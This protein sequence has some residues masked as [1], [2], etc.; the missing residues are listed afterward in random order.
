MF[1]QFIDKVEGADT[2]MITS[3]I[4]FMA[5]FVVVSLYLFVMDKNY[6]TKMQNLPLEDNQDDYKDVISI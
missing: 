3:F 6:L 1:K 2:F 4:I 5:F